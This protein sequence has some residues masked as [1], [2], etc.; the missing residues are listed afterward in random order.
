MY[1][2]VIVGAGV[3]GNWRNVRFDDGYRPLSSSNSNHSDQLTE[4]DADTVSTHVL[5]SPPAQC[6]PDGHRFS[7]ESHGVQGAIDQQVLITVNQQPTNVSSSGCV[8]LANSAR[9][10]QPRMHRGPRVQT[11]PPS[12]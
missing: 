10:L 4:S 8:P 11:R 1:D 12:S 9:R 7:A 5:A 6:P 3:A 2:V